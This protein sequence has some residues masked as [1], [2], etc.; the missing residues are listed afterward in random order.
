MLNKQ[1]YNPFLSVIFI[2]FR[3]L[4]GTGF[5]LFGIWTLALILFYGWYA[6]DYGRAEHLRFDY[7]FWLMYISTTLCWG[8]LWLVPGAYLMST[9]I[10]FNDWIGYT[11]RQRWSIW[12]GLWVFSLLICMFS[13]SLIH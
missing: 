6:F 8:Y 2:S 7:I 1:P 4:I 13:Y 3:I 11:I 12:L 10:L 9:Q 5:V